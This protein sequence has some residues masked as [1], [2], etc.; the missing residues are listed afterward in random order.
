MDVS[1]EVAPAPEP[2]PE[3]AGVPGHPP[4][5]GCPKC[6]PELVALK[7]V[8]EKGDAAA[9]NLDV[10]EMEAME[11]AAALYV[12]ALAGFAAAGVKRPKVQDKLDAANDRCADL[13]VSGGGKEMVVVDWD[14]LSDSGLTAQL[15]ASG[16]LGVLCC[17]DD[18]KDITTTFDEASAYGAW[19]LTQEMSA[20]TRIVRSNKT[21]S[22]KR[23]PPQL[24]FQG[25]LREVACARNVI[26]GL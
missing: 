19:D 10:P 18:A 16:Y 4:T 2:E 25:D 3:P 17:T 6:K 21:V 8:V 9:K 20:M 24:D 12:E 15:Q 1:V 22:A 5:C 14:D 7:L 26:V 13:L 23:P 11:A